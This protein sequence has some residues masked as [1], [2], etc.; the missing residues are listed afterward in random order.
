M[1]TMRM[2]APPSIH[3]GEPFTEGDGPTASRPVEHTRSGL[4]AGKSM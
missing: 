3:M 2:G 4:G 1:T